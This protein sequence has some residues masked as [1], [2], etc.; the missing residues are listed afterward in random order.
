M[1]LSQGGLGE[2]YRHGLRSK[3]SSYIPNESLSQRH[4]M[5][6]HEKLEW[7]CR[8]SRVGRQTNGETPRDSNT[9]SRS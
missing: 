1:V 8:G 4:D 3:S 6:V 7:A 9:S 2:F 5:K